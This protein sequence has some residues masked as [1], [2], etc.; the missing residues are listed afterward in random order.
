M[1]T[2]LLALLLVLL[3]TFHVSACKEN[4]IP[5][6]P[7]DINPPNPVVTP[8][9]STES[10]E[11]NPQVVKPAKDLPTVMTELEPSVVFIATKIYGSEVWSFGSGVIVDRRG[12]ILTNYHLIKQPEIIEENKGGAL[13][14]DWHVIS[15]PETIY[16][17][18]NRNGA[19]KTEFEKEHIACLVG[20]NEE[21]DLAVIKV[22]SKEDNLPEAILGDS[23]AMK[24]GESV[25][26]MGYPLQGLLRNDQ[27]TSVSPSFTTGIVSDIRM[28]NGINCIQTDASMNP[29]NS[30]GPLVN[31]KGEVVGIN[32]S[33]FLVDVYTG[34]VKEL[35]D[36]PNCNPKTQ[37]GT[38][39][40][41]AFAER[42]TTEKISLYEGIGFSVN[43]NEAK[44]LLSKVIPS[45]LRPLT[46]PLTLSGVR[47]Q[48]I[49]DNATIEWDTDEPATSQVDYQWHTSDCAEKTSW[50]TDYHKCCA[51]YIR[52]PSYN[53]CIEV[54][55]L[56]KARVLLNT[57]L[58]THHKVILSVDSNDFKGLRNPIIE[59][60]NTITE[61]TRT[62]NL[63][64][65]DLRGMYDFKIISR[66]ESGRE[67]ISEP[68]WFFWPPK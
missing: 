8:E 57:N 29:G 63:T 1:R 21:A 37:F 42:P 39:R 59:S 17:F 56:S 50:G 53:A 3:S 25:I 60:Y 6:S 61:Q 18:L 45:P 54:C 65:F 16:V 64:D 32:T 11:K 24:K 35:F 13:Q 43:I 12:Y 66:S 14:F 52:A 44:S 36:L 49:W 48:V 34:K 33:K 67:V 2:Q 9:K 30:G 7:P 38:P 26:V 23:A 19:T 4:S 15:P 20:K 51:P 62:I 58:T 28:I 41:W 22:S 47:S 5:L 40:F 27:S 46:P 55:K 31:T 10:K 68:Y